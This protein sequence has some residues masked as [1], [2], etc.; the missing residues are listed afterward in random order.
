MATA[1][2]TISPYQVQEVSLLQQLLSTQ[3]VNTLEN[4][5]S[6]QTLKKQLRLDKIRFG[7]FIAIFVSILIYMLTVYISIRTRYSLMIESLEKVPSSSYGNRSAWYVAFAYEYPLFSQYINKNFPAAVVYGYYSQAYSATMLS[8]AATIIPQMYSF[9]T[10]GANNAVL[11]DAQSIL[12]NSFQQYVQSTAC[13]QNCPGPTNMPW[14]DFVSAGLAT[15]TSGAFL[16]L[17]GGPVGMVIG[18]IVGFGVGAGL[19]FGK[20][21]TQNSNCHNSIWCIG[22]VTCSGGS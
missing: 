13:E 10:L 18:G 1:T 8:D 6:E 14:Y 17:E 9:S 4:L 20:Q 3:R 2:T 16:G 19:A 5:E 22:G 15:A 7:L 21:A 11:P 12:C